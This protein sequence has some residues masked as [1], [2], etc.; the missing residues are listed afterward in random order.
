MYHIL[1][2]FTLSPKSFPMHLNNKDDA[3][4]PPAIVVIIPHLSLCP[5]SLSL[6]LKDDEVTSSLLSPLRQ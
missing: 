1:L 2:H 6:W 4:S 5:T 3:N